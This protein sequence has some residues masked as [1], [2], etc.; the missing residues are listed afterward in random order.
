MEDHINYKELREKKIM[1]L[2]HL[3]QNQGYPVARIYDAELKQVHTE[4]I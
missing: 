4:R 3:L 2:V 1:Y